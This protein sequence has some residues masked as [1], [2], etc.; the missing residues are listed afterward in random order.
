M[1][2][3][4]KTVENVDSEKISRKC[5]Q[6]KKQQKMQIDSKTEQE[7]VDSFSDNCRQFYDSARNCKWFQ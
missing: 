5:R 4:K 6:S 7:T 1:Q 3:V 2:I